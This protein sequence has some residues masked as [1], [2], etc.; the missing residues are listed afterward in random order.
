[1]TSP[2]MESTIVAEKDRKLNGEYKV[3]VPRLTR[4][5]V[6]SLEA[7]QQFCLKKYVEAHKKED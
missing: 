7:I 2:E 5:S 3:S 1:M 4:E 6:F